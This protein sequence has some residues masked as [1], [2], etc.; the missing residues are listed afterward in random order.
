MAATIA[1]GVATRQRLWL[2]FAVADWAFFIS[3]V[4]S[5]LNYPWN[6]L[7]T[8]V[9]LISPFFLYKSLNNHDEF[10]HWGNNQS[11]NA[12]TGHKMTSI[13]RA[14]YLALGAVCWSIFIYLIPPFP[15]APYPT[16]VPHDTMLRGI[17]GLLSLFLWSAA[18][19]VNI[20]NDS[21]WR[22]V[23]GSWSLRHERGPQPTKTWNRIGWVLLIS[24]QAVWVLFVA[25]V[26]C[27]LVGHW[28]LLRELASNGSPF[29][30]LCALYLSIKRKHKGEMAAIS[31]LETHHKKAIS[32][33]IDSQRPGPS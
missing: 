33:R 29:V 4:P 32:D 14:I 1:K 30:L 2:A 9:G 23:L 20:T 16:L 24:A 12:P 17:L 10:A 28:R 8:F 15:I 3:Y 25:Q 13:A 18:A 11:P 26:Q 22:N 19:F 5:Q 6:L 7:N 21:F 27:N 31:A